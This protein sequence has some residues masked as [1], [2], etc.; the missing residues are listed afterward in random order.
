MLGILKLR[1]G[2]D[3]QVVR[4]RMADRESFSYQIVPVNT[5]SNK[6]KT[7][8]EIL[9]KYLP[10]ALRQESL[11]DLLRLENQRREKA[12]GIIFCIY[13]DPHGNH[14]IHDG[15]AHYLYETMGELEP[16]MRFDEMAGWMQKYREDA[17]GTGKVRAFAGKTPT[18][19][20]ECFSY[21]YTSRSRSFPTPKAGE[22]ALADEEQETEA[23]TGRM[24]ICGNCGHRFDEVDAREPKNWEQLVE[25]NQAG[26]KESRFDIL[27]ATKGFGM[28][29]DKSSVRFVVHTS[30][31]SGI[32]S[33]YQEVGRAGRDHERAHI[34]LLVD[35]PTDSCRAE[36]EAKVIKKPACKD[37][38][39]CP[40]GRDSLCDYG[41]QH[42][43]ITRSYPGAESN[44]VSALRVL[45]KLIMA[46]E[47]NSDRSVVLSTSR[48]YL[49]HTELAV[50]RLT[51]L[52]LV[53]DYAVTYQ[54]NNPHFDVEFL[55][56]D[57]PEN[58]FTLTRIQKKMQECLA[59]YFSHFPNRRN[60]SI[61]RELELRTKE[62]KQ[63]ETLH[64]RTQQFATIERYKNLFQTV[65]RHLLLLLDHTYKEVVKMRYDMLWNLVD[66]VRSNTLGECRRKPL[67]QHL[68]SDEEKSRYE[69]YRCGLC[70]VC[71]ET[72]EFTQDI[73]NQPQGPPSDIRKEAE[74]TNLLNEDWFEFEKLVV[75]AD[76]FRGLDP[77]F[78]HRR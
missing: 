5:G 78:G 18:L 72:L 12:V 42:M 34:V 19:C 75:L 63:L 46:S 41:K 4:D 61:E 40:R 1:G 65:Y 44:A 16:E 29:I 31:P 52:G 77:R 45:D 64:A 3:G 10:K 54:R 7:Y 58:P 50:Y 68:I 24:K 25:A 14:L 43:F 47:E 2:E 69:T 30:L 28:G 71:V 48:Q 9:D 21:E 62:Y 32:E 49:S 51:V 11:A 26:F 36:L 76:T 38:H 23:Q 74:L 39:T 59:E 15:I 17:Y 60:R 66:V 27:V 73:A 53:E 20:P 70:D 55:L 67:L 13:A 8:H 35:P 6:T 56:P 37:Y 57:T 22:E 33:W